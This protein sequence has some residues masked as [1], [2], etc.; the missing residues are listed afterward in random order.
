VALSAIQTADADKTLTSS[1]NRYQ[2]FTGLSTSR[3][4]Y[5]PT[6]SILRGDIWVIENTTSYDLVIRSSDASIINVA[7]GSNSKATI[8]NAAITLRSTKNTP[9]SP[10][11]WRVLVTGD[12]KEI[13]P[14]K[15]AN[16]QA[17]PGEIIACNTLGGPFTV[18]MPS[19]P[20]L[21]DTVEILDARSN[22]GVNPV[23][24]DRNGEPINNSASN[25][26]CN[27]STKRYVATYM[28]TT[29]GWF[30]SYF[31]EQQ[32]STIKTSAYTAVR[33]DK[34]LTDTSVT[35]FTVNAPATPAV[36]DFFEVYDVAGTWGVG[37]KNLTIGRNFSKINGA[38]SDYTCN[39]SEKRVYAVYV[40]L[41]QG[42]RVYV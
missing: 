27:L 17:S 4:L 42:W 32:Y 20:T 35:G 3:N 40:S 13:T 21:G 24:L 2:I 25:Y 10:T 15:T 1:D 6:T 16:Y 30:A 5:L 23:T 36:G 34:V 14:I 33:G 31:G 29:F 39:V 28:D 12:H 37:G 38:T 22:F 18:T 8:R 7:N 11:H 19:N 41:A 9:T 26:D